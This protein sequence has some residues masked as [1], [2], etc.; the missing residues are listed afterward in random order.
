[1]KIKNDKFLFNIKN[2]YTSRYKYKA[3]KKTKKEKEKE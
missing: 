3:E 1:M 2:P